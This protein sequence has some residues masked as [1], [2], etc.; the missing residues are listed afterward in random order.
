MKRKILNSVI[1]L[2]FVSAFFFGQVVEE[3]LAV[4]ENL[5][6]NKYEEA[7]KKFN[8]LDQSSSIYDFNEIIVILEAAKRD[9]TL[10]PSLLAYLKESYDY[11]AQ[12]YFNLGDEPKAEADIVSILN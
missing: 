11:R 3:D 2:F 10:S 1:F 8:S 6:K 4:S 7:V 9:K 12:V 5:I